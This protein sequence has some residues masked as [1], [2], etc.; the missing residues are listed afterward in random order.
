MQRMLGM[1]KPETG[2]VF[3]LAAPGVLFRGGKEGRIREGIV[4]ANILEAVI[5]L[6]DRMFHHTAIQVV[7]LLFNRAKKDESVLFIDAS[8]SYH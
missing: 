5:A 6:P 4:R 8:G 2:K 1:V 3:T 7:A